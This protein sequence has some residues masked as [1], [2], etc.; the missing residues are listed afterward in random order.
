MPIVVRTQPVETLEPTEYDPP[1]FTVSWVPAL[2][3]KVPVVMP[4]LRVKNMSLMFCPTSVGLESRLFKVTVTVPGPVVKIAE[5]STVLPPDDVPLPMKV[6][7]VPNAAALN[8]SATTIEKILRMLVPPVRLWSA[9][10]HT[11]A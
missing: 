3:A 9:P 7:V 2:E 1:E 8:P 5:A 10:Q 11:I 4:L 6:M